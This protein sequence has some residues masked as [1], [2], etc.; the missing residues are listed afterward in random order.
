[1]ELTSV[2]DIQRCNAKFSVG[3]TVSRIS[4]TNLTMEFFSPWNIWPSILVPLP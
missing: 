3:T 2:F 1:M 4:Q